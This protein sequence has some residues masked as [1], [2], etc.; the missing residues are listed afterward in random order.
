[1]GFF[2][3][4]PFAF[5]VVGALRSIVSAIAKPSTRPRRPTLASPRAHPSAAFDVSSLCPSQSSSKNH[6]PFSRLEPS[7]ILCF[8]WVTTV[9][10]RN[11]SRLEF[12]TIETLERLG[13]RILVGRSANCEPNREMPP[14]PA[15]VPGAFICSSKRLG[16]APYRFR[17][18]QAGSSDGPPSRRNCE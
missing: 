17:S 14:P 15:F 11:A 9:S 12:R 7:R 13:R 16:A 5:A 6:A 3:G 18:G 2:F 4:S 10:N 8:V 1:M